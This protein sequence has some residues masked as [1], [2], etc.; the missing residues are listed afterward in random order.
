MDNK[1]ACKWAINH[2]NVYEKGIPP[3]W[4]EVNNS[5]LYAGM[6]PEPKPHKAY[7]H[8]VACSQK[9]SSSVCHNPTLLALFLDTTVNQKLILRPENAE[10][11][12]LV[13]FFFFS[14]FLSFAVQLTLEAQGKEENKRFLS[15]GWAPVSPDVGWLPVELL[16]ELAFQPHLQYWN[17]L[18]TGAVESPSLDIF[19]RWVDVPLTG[20]V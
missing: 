7:W 17:R 11:G 9:W 10:E 16:L 4:R 12:I 5:P 6:S 13:L 18:P 1:W 8:S 20:T 19:K 14:P 15:L 3:A 2:S